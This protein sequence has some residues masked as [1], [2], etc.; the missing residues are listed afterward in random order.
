MTP[1]CLA[2]PVPPGL[3]CHARPLV[4]AAI[5]T[6]PAKAALLRDRHIEAAAAAEGTHNAIAAPLDPFTYITSAQLWIATQS[7]IPHLPL[8]LDAICG[9]ARS[10]LPLAAM[11]AMHLHLPLWSVSRA[12]GV[13]DPGHGWRLTDGAPIPTYRPND[14]DPHHLLVIDDTV[15]NGFTMAECSEILR[16]RWPAA[17]LT[18]AVIYAHPQALSQVDLCVSHYPGPHYL[19][20]NWPNTAHAERCAFDFDGIL[21]EDLPVGATREPR[22][23]YLPRR[24]PIPM[25][26]S[27]RPESVRGLS[28]DWLARHGIQYQ[29]MYLRDFA[30]DSWQAIAE[31]KAAHY[32]LSSCTLF[33]ESDP[34]QAVL[35]RDRTNKPVLC[36]AAVCVFPPM[37]GPRSDRKCC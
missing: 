8:D 1:R 21:C 2:C 12:V 28:A 9:I 14:A 20:W 37:Q 26:V 13:T 23:L 5:A 11:I 35:I 7:L 31:F 29:A 4:C 3:E 15:A 33:A 17:T 18:R 10:G 16:R 19:E 34:R 24:R 36:P 32:G 22:P 30:D 25:I 27:G 6:D